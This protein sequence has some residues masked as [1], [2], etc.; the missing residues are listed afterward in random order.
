MPAPLQITL[1]GET[2]LAISRHFAA[3]PE[4]V[5]RAHT[6]CA[7]IQRWMTGPP[8]WTM[9]GCALDLRPGGG[10]R[11][12]YASADGSGFSITGEFLEVEPGRRILFTQRMLMPDP[13]PDTRCDTLFEPNGAGTRLTFRMETFDADIRAAML[14]S[15]AFDG[16]EH[17]YRSLDKLVAEIDA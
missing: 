17:S 13:T 4:I 7:L 11:Y 3:P 9:P 5:F 16:Q 6:D 14:S 2:D 12:D 10:F 8:G 15:G 1:D